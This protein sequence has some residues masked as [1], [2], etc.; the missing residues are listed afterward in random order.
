MRQK[1]YGSRSPTRDIDMRDAS[2]GL[3]TGGKHQRDLDH[4]SPV[5]SASNEYIMQL[6]QD[7]V[8]LQKRLNLVLQELDR[9][10]RDRSSLVQKLSHVDQEISSL[11]GRLNAEDE[12]DRRNN[13][14]QLDLNGQRD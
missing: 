8:S 4:V 14:F 10:N 6:R 9:V 3:L 2:H 12:A 7:N 5:R 13:D 11:Q 1:N